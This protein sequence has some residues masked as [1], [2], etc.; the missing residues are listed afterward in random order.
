MECAGEGDYAKEK[1]LGATPHTKRHFTRSMFNDRKYCARDRESQ[2]RIHYYR[3][4]NLS[5]TLDD[6]LRYLS[7]YRHPNVHSSG[8]IK[9]EISSSIRR[10]TQSVQR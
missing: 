3:Q 2:I 4:F 7:I 10:H 1:R 8:G 9:I 6:K 5:L